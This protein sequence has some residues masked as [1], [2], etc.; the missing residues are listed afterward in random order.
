MITKSKDTQ[1]SFSSTR[2]KRLTTMAK[3][4]KNTSLVK[5][6]M[7]CKAVDDGDSLK[8]TVFVSKSGIIRHA[9]VQAG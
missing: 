9:F 1:P 2:E 3:D 4:Q 7:S 6:L 5:F 8:G